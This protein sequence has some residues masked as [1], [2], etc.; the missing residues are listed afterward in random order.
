MNTNASE[1]PVNIRSHS[2]ASVQHS[3]SYNATIIIECSIHNYQSK[4]FSNILNEIESP[5]VPTSESIGQLL[6]YVYS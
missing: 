6:I 4:Q 2:Y 1:Y 5:T 3:I